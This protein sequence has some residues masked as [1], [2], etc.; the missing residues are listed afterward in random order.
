[1][2]LK[3]LLLRV[4]ETFEEKV[5]LPVKYR[6]EI[7]RVISKSQEIENLQFDK[8][9]ARETL[10]IIGMIFDF[11]F[12]VLEKLGVSDLAEQIG[13]ELAQ[14]AK[15]RHQEVCKDSSLETMAHLIILMFIY[16]YTANCRLERFIS[17]IEYFNLD[18]SPSIVPSPGD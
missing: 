2:H 6:Q 4:L 10:E 18:C 14:F 1:M 15:D 5:R 12:S 7:Q 11:G 9:K 16:G 3:Q 13:Y 17:I 8:E